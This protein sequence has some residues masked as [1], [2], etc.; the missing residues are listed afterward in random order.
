[1]THAPF[2]A[3][4]LADHGSW[5]SRV[6]R[7]HPLLVVT[8]AV[9]NGKSTLYA[10]LAH[11]TPMSMMDV[12]SESVGWAHIDLLTVGVD[13]QAGFWNFI[14]SKIG[15]PAS[16]IEPLL[17]GDPLPTGE[18]GQKE[19]HRI[20]NFLDAVSKRVPD[21]KRFILVLDHWDAARAGSLV[22]LSGVQA[23]TEEIASRVNDEADH[24]VGCVILTR[25]PTTS[26]I[27]T[28][29][30]ALRDT[31][32]GLQRISGTIERQ[33]H[34]VP[35]GFL[36][37]AASAAAL[38]VLGVPTQHHDSVYEYC[39]GWLDLLVCAADQIVNNPDQSWGPAEQEIVARRAFDQI[40]DP[41][42]RWWI[43]DP[44]MRSLSY[45]R[46]DLDSN[47]RRL[48]EI[49]RAGRIDPAKYETAAL[50][51]DVNNAATGKNL[52]APAIYAN[53]TEHQ[54]LVVDTENIAMR[55]VSVVERTWGKTMSQ[56]DQ[57]RLRQGTLGALQRIGLAQK[58]NRIA[59]EFNIPR[60]NVVIVEQNHKRVT[61]IF[62]ETLDAQ[63]QV[64]VTALQGP[65]LKAKAKDSHDDAVGARWLAEKSLQYPNSTFYVLS[66]DNDYIGNQGAGAFLRGCEYVLL[67]PWSRTPQTEAP[68]V[69][70]AANRL[71]WTLN[72][73]FLDA[74]PANERIPLSFHQVWSQIESQDPGYARKYPR[75]S[76]GSNRA[77]NNTRAGNR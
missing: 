16:D 68:N 27:G 19:D 32:P 23:L 35:L 59:D 8:G 17:T 61:E 54:F 6:V 45:Q 1:M 43:P 37:G 26:M 63:W 33:Y 76:P 49:V 51:V 66:G 29:A 2:A 28:W 71:K 40:S 67:Y 53:V 77:R 12:T 42:L 18:P 22:Y 15:M 46:S 39:G 50:P 11:Q 25:F 4:V 48:N 62:G 34:P 56:D 47:Q 75:P 65:E 38:G 44:K 21:G 14:G 60:N 3:A 57:R 10:A 70:S 58:I 7:N 74:I 41:A 5:A 55:Y 20:P 73:T 13:T 64:E 72:S 52:P 24:S 36:S 9:K 30:R 31:V 69:V